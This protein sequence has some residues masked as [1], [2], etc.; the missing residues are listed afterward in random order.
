MSKRKRL[1]F[2][3]ADIGFCLAWDYPPL[4]GADHPYYQGFLF[5]R[6]IDQLRKELR[7]FVEINLYWAKGENKRPA[8]KGARKI[9]SFPK[10]WNLYKNNTCYIMEMF[11]PL[12]ER[13]L[14]FAE[15]DFAFKDVEYYLLGPEDGLQRVNG[16]V[17]REYWLLS[18]PIDPLIKSLLINIL[19]R[20]GGFLL[21]S[22]GVIVNN[23]GLVFCGESGSGKST[24]AEFFRLDKETIVLTD[25]NLVIAKKEGKFSINATPWP[26]GA[27]ISYASRAPLKNVFFIRHAKNNLLLPLKPH[28]AFKKILSQTVLCVWERPWLDSLLDFLRELSEKI[29]FFDLEF[30]NERSVVDFLKK[31]ISL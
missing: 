22:A 1:L 13:L 24:L 14:S 17:F 5:K 15:I 26:G 19:A 27:R 4:L 3:V 28:E 21:H 7:K 25:E 30:V 23:C 6:G 18:Q 20:E 12:K 29:E 31:K 10:F 16:R 11:H 2:N 9:L 8:L